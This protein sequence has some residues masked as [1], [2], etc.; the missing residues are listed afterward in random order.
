M[1]LEAFR[2]A[3]A[4]LRS[5]QRQTKPF[6]PDYDALAISLAAFQE[7]AQEL[8]GEENFYGARG[9]HR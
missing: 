5:L 3:V 4:I 8:S 7:L 9:D 6:S 2:P 1:D